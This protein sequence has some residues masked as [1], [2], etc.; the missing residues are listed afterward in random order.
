MTCVPIG[1]GVLWCREL[2]ELIRRKTRGT[3]AHTR[4]S[5]CRLGGPVLLKKGRTKSADIDRSGQI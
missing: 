2:S 1:H 5:C 3:I 4:D